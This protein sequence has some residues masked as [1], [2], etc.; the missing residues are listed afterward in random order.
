MIQ[1][2]RRHCVLL[3]AL[4]STFVLPAT[5]GATDPITASTLTG[6]VT[7]VTTDSHVIKGTVQ[8]VTPELLTVLPAPTP[9]PKARPGVAPAEAPAA[10]EPM[11]LEWKDIKRT[12]DGLSAATA[13]AMWRA[14]HTAA[15]LCPTC[16]GERTIWCPTCKGT[17]HDPAAAANCKT[18]KGELLVPCKS[19][20]EADGLVPCTN[21]CLRL[22]VGSWSKH[23]DDGLMW[24][25]FN[26]GGNTTPLFSEHH[27]GDVI[28]VDFKTHTATD[29]GKCPICGGTTKV[30]DPICHGSGKVPCPECLARKTAGPCP[31]HCAAGRVVCPDCGGSGLR[32]T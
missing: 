20:K 13:L 18:C 15:E 3:V 21:G 7:V 31:A 2:C 22:G 29:A 30:D 28:V 1:T 23:A 12:S 8:S 9:A 26:V 16:R 4:V 24:C 14:Q 27:V 17:N 10:P 32:K 11:P 25:R 6:P 5:R 19:K